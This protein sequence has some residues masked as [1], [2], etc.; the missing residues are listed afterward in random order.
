MKT[1]SSAISAYSVLLS[2]FYTG[3]APEAEHIAFSAFAK[4]KSPLDAPI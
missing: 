4:P 1:A 3:R 2:T